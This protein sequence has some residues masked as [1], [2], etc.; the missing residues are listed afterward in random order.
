MFSVCFYIESEILILKFFCLILHEISKNCLRRKAIFHLLIY[1]SKNYKAK[2]NQTISIINPI[3]IYGPAE[4]PTPPPKKYNSHFLLQFNEIIFRHIFLYSHF[5]TPKKKWNKITRK[6][7]AKICLF[8]YNVAQ[9][10]KNQH[11]LLGRFNSQLMI[12]LSGL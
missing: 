2:F 5:S 11:N 10:E 7:I 8:L 12:N 1:H 3:F 9:D 4:H 6:F